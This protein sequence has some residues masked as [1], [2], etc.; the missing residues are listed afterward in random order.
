MT[1]RYEAEELR[2]LKEDHKIAIRVLKRAKQIL[3]SPKRWVRGDF[4]FTKDMVPV[5]SC[6]EEAFCFCMAGAIERAECDLGLE[7]TW[8]HAVDASGMLKEALP[9]KF[10]SIP[11]YNDAP[12]RTY[13]QV[14]K[15]LDK[16]IVLG[17]RHLDKLKTTKTKESQ[18]V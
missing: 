3:S 12:G 18:Y 9:K 16:A 15:T 2:E 4:A 8:N 10:H 17:K 7:N 14:I 6:T 5:G 1:E 11:G 13:L